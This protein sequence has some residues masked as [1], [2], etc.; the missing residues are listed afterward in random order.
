MWQSLAGNRCCFIATDCVHASLLLLS[1]KHFP[2]V[3]WIEQTLTEVGRQEMLLKFDYAV[4]VWFIQLTTC[5]KYA[6]GRV[7]Q[8]SCCIVGTHF[9]IQDMANLNLPEPTVQSIYLSRMIH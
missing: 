3:L 7:L 6:P 9:D 8:W 4:D 1:V 5:S 2:R